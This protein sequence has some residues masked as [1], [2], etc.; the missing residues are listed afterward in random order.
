MCKVHGRADYF[1]CS[2]WLKN[3][4]TNVPGIFVDE[5][6]YGEDLSGSG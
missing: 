5:V 4:I 2:S 6:V 3:V 1:E